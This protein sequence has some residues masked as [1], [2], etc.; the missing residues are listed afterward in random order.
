MTYGLQKAVVP[1]VSKLAEPS[2][3]LDQ[4][5]GQIVTKGKLARH[6]LDAEMS[7]LAYWSFH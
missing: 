7:A 6:L 5:H 3:R 2:E 4:S 1:L